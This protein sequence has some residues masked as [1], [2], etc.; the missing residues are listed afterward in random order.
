MG[1]LNS[2]FL[3]GVL[4][5]IDKHLINTVRTMATRIVSGILC[6]LALVCCAGFSV[7]VY[8]E[9]QLVSVTSQSSSLY[10]DESFVCSVRY[11]NT[12]KALTTGVGIRVHYDSSQLSIDSITNVLFQSKVGIQVKQDTA[13]HDDDVLTDTFILAGWA[14]T[15]AGWPGQLDLP[16]TLF[17]ITYMTSKAFKGSQVNVTVSSGDVNY[18][19]LGG[20]LKLDSAEY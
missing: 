6:R 10:S 5:S 3:W 11:D 16:V 13:D 17:D 2:I 7:A 1:A 19:V 14:D 20:Y 18:S 8:A 15:N 4:I 12:D 9:S